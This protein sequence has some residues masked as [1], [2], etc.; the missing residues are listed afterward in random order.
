[1][2]QD[3][4][5]SRDRLFQEIGRGSIS[6]A[7]DLLEQNPDLPVHLDNS[8]DTDIDQDDDHDEEALDEESEL[9]KP[10]ETA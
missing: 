4:Q 3:V 2:I 1:M 6:Y 10:R 5:Q 8:S 9:I 7:D